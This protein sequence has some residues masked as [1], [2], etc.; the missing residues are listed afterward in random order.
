[1]HFISFDPIR[2]VAQSGPD[3]FDA[4]RRERLT[5]ATG[6]GVGGSAANVA[7]ELSSAPDRILSL[8]AGAQ[9]GWALD[10]AV[11]AAGMI[12]TLVFPSDS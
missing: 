6:T 11:D 10:S 4:R 1:M 2:P 9:R 12:H 5:F 8:L 7:F 3:Y